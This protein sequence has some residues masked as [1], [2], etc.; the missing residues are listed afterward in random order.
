MED[1]DVEACASRVQMV[2]PEDLHEGSRP[3]RHRFRGYPPG[4][5]V[6]EVWEGEGD[7]AS[8]DH[9]SGGHP[10]GSGASPTGS[11][12]VIGYAQSHPWA[13]PKPPSVTIPEDAL[14]RIPAPTEPGVDHYF[15]FDIA[16]LVKGQKIGE[17]LLDS[18]L[19]VARS[20]GFE[21]VRLVAV[22]GAH[23]YWARFGFEEYKRVGPGKEYGYG[24]GI[25]VYMKRKV[26]GGEAEMV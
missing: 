18:A 21:E 16:T 8:A 22:R 25:A 19:G 1:A 17:A 2:Y 15:I 10:S 3:Y 11:W 23:T 5:F 26:A 13:G 24:D 4:C 6:A 20:L 9:P 14:E 12:Q 7:S